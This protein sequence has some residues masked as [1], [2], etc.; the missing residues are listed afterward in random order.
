MYNAQCTMYNIPPA[1]TQSL[2]NEF[3]EPRTH[4]VI[5]FAGVSCAWLIGVYQK[6][7]KPKGKQHW[8]SLKTHTAHMQLGSFIR[9]RAL[10][11]IG[12]VIFLNIR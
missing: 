11:K 5:V 6:H 3:L 1:R 12:T 2:H 10:R 9:K 7:K 4:L 8:R